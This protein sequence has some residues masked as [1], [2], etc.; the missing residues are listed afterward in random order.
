[1]REAGFGTGPAGTASAAVVSDTLRL[2]ILR[3]DF[4]QDSIPDSTTGN[5]RFDLRRDTGI[6]VDPPPHDKAYFEAHGRAL[7]RYYGVQSYGSLDIAPTVFPAGAE[8]AYHLND[9]ADYGPW[10]VAQDEA[11]YAMAERFIT[12]ALR[13]AD[14][15]GDVDFSAFDAFV[16][17]HAGADFQGDINRDTGRDIPAFT[18][19][20]GDSLQLS[21]GKVGRVL[22]LPETSSQDGR[23]AALNG[24]FAHEFGHVLGLPD[25]YNIFNGVP[26]VGYFS[27]MDSG[28]NIGVVVVDPETEE[29]I[30]VDGVFPTSLD[31][32]SRWQ[33]FPDAVELDLPGES[34]SASLEAVEASPTLP[35]VAIDGPQYFLVENRCLDLDG[36]G[37]PY[38]EQDT[39]TGVFLGPTD[40]PSLPG[41]G[42]RFEYDAVLPGGGVLIW[43]IDESIIEE[44]LSTTGAVNSWTL[45]RGVAVEEADGISDQGR[46]GYGDWE[47]MFCTPGPGDR[48]FN[49][50][51]GP[52]TVPGSDANDGAWSGITI[53]VTSPPGRFMQVAITRPQAKDGWPVRFV[54]GPD[55][56]VTPG[57][58]QLV[59]LDGDGSEEV[60]Y[61]FDASQGTGV[62]E[63]GWG[64]LRGDGT[65]FP[66]P[67][68]GAPLAAPIPDPLRGGL[69]ASGEFVIAAGEAATAVVAG[70]SG[71][72][73]FL[74]TVDGV[75]HIVGSPPPAE[76]PPVLVPGTGGG[77]L[78]LYGGTASL[79]GVT[80]TGTP[81]YADTVAEAEGGLPVAG[82]VPYGFASDPSVPAA[83]AL[84]FEGGILA[85][86]EFP[87]PGPNGPR[88]RRTA[89]EI[90]ALAAGWVGGSPDAAS[91]VAV[92]SDSVLVLEGT[93]G[94]LRAGWPAPEGARPGRLLLGDLDA[95]GLSEI[96]LPTE[97]GVI[98]AWNGD[99]SP[100][101]GWPRVV[102][103]P[104]K[105]L[106]LLD[107]D[108]DGDLDVFALDGLGRF[109]GF[110]GRGQVL[111]GF[112]RAAAVLPFGT[113]AIGDVDGSG[114]LVWVAPSPEGGLLLA[115]NLPGA[116][117][118][119]GEW[120]RSGGRTEGGNY[121]AVPSGSEP[122]PG[123]PALGEP[124]LVY[125]NPVRGSG[126]EIRF[127]L[128]TGESAQLTL[129]DV[130]GRELQDASLD[131][132]GGFRPG[133]NSA[134]WDV[135][136]VAPG[137]Y[138]CRLERDG[139]SGRRVDLAKI[140]VLR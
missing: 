103:A 135:G 106:E 99:G 140:L 78:I 132:R 121:Q 20:F 71:T 46:F 38:V 105:D 47:D 138:F 109:Q 33:L 94:A 25:L 51:F 8:D 49:G 17:V 66:L 29:Q 116:A 28:E 84:A 44:G 16:V 11:V 134:R 41:A 58:L 75:N 72:R 137:L 129:L 131:L 62:T 112:P 63:Q 128:T 81:V 36:N 104:V 19:T 64:A 120:R 54:R 91:L 45:D 34:W 68:G 48:C 14:A 52:D 139:P 97:G 80:G 60:L 43:H 1:L 98:Q 102:P 40:D 3:V 110:S 67:G 35:L 117:P 127:L 85:L 77:D 30:E 136:G 125:P 65:P 93:S 42:G 133:E 114:R 92:T 89:G 83:V 115:R 10:E 59:D 88:I 95:D 5:G 9:T 118:A 23:L 69:V 111:P 18:L 27:L 32:W 79:R 74:W 15:T 13:A 21:T 55:L 24:V 90:L 96:L 101:V 100:V 124:L 12:D 119:A 82:P 50:T 126:V 61:S 113:P 86:H 26:Q 7:A 37:F 39:T 73:P 76:T 6:P 87:S 56:L 122:V 123:E 2:A 107:L 22:V 53:D 70:V 57:P 130:V 108:G 4:L 31:P